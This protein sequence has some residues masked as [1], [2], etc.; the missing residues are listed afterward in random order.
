MSFKEALACGSFSHGF[1]DLVHSTHQGL[2]PLWMFEEEILALAAP[3][4]IALLGKFPVK[5]PTLHTI[6]KFF[7]AL[8]LSGEFSVTLLDPRHVNPD[9]KSSNEGTGGLRPTN[10]PESC[11]LDISDV[12]VASVLP[13][14][15]NGEPISLAHLRSRLGID[16]RVVL[17][18]ISLSNDDIRLN[19]GENILTSNSHVHD[20]VSTNPDPNEVCRNSCIA[21]VVVPKVNDVVYNLPMENNTQHKTDVSNKLAR[22]GSFDDF[23][24]ASSKKKRRNGNKNKLIGLISNFS[25][26]VVSSLAILEIG[27]FAVGARLFV[28]LFSLVAG[29]IVCFSLVSWS[30]KDLVGTC[31]FVYAAGFLQILSDVMEFGRWKIVIFGS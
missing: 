21:P 11:W 17:P 24:R 28:F 10:V 26:L 23:E 27:A 8:K 7:F 9:H 29:V 30:C 20:V 12:V 2:L 5:R 25:L 18:V 22:H 13:L 19:E 1:P 3:F 31:F 4:E 15:N 14:T 16:L 6:R